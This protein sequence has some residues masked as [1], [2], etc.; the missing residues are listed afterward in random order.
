[1]F[2]VAIDQQLTATDYAVVAGVNR[3]APMNQVA[4]TLTA[5]QTST[6][7]YLPCPVTPAS[8]GPCSNGAVRIISKAEN[9]AFEGLALAGGVVS[10]VGLPTAADHLI[11]FVAGQ[12]PL[13][14]LPAPS[15]PNS[16][17]NTAELLFNIGL[18]FAAGT[19]PYAG[20]IYE[21]QY[22][23]TSL[24]HADTIRGDSDFQSLIFETV[25]LH[26][27]EVLA[28]FSGLPTGSNFTFPAW[29]AI[30]CSSALKAGYVGPCPAG[31]NTGFVDT[32]ASTADFPALFPCSAGQGSLPP[33]V[34]PQSLSGKECDLTF[35]T[36]TN[37]NYA[38]GRA[39]YNFT[40][41]ANVTSVDSSHF[42]LNNVSLIGYLY[43][44]YQWNPAIDPSLDKH[45]SNIQAGSNAADR[46]GQVFRIKVTLDTSSP[47]VLPYAF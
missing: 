7:F 4:D 43:D 20:P 39:G 47:I 16:N 36:S 23:S 26:K 25:A 15:S 38:F 35:S 14:A 30:G 45:L 1:V 12:A 19:S 46:V 11:A 2:S 41:I 13:R 9:I 22:A 44:T 3:N 10:L 29:Q 33:G 28:H 40:L 18:V 27:A 24:T 34:T 21:Y 17:V 42:L 32:P 37:L 6:W 31:G 8:Y 5:P